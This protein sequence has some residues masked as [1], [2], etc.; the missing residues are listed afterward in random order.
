MIRS[1]AMA[2]AGLWIVA[3]DDFDDLLV[4]LCFD[5]VHTGLRNLLSGW[6]GWSQWYK[7]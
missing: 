1:D 5:A 6:M 7:S 4:I 3:V 2:V